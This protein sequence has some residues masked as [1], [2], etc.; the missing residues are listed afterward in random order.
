MCQLTLPNFETIFPTSQLVKD[1]QLSAKSVEA[2]RRIYLE[3][4]VLTGSEC[5]D[6][7]TVVSMSQWRRGKSRRE[8]SG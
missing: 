8:L 7:D 1:E 5:R 3:S 6:G 2:L 4:Q